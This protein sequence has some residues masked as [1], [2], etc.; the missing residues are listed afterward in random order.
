MPEVILASAKI[1]TVIGSYD[2]QRRRL[3][4]AGHWPKRIQKI[5]RKDRYYKTRTRENWSQRAHASEESISAKVWSRRKESAI[6]N[7][8]RL[9]RGPPGIRRV[10]AE[11]PVHFAPGQNGY[12]GIVVVPRRGLSR[13]EAAQYVGIGTTKFDEMVKDRRMP[14]SFAIDTRVLW[15]IRDLDIA[16]DALKE[17]LVTNPWDRLA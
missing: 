7:R 13:A 9:K 17:G 10:V 3:E 14:R 16:I 2:E 4:A 8:T 11:S 6:R 1:S 5:P 12:R 15:D